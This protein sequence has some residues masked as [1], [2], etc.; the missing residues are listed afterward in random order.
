MKL[1]TNRALLFLFSLLCFF[2]VF[3][4]DD[5]TS[6]AQSKT[7]KFTPIPEQEKELSVFIAEMVRMLKAGENEKFLQCCINPKEI[8][9]LLTEMPFDKFVEGFSTEAAAGL[10]KALES[11]KGKEP[12]YNKERTTARFEVPDTDEESGKKSYINFQKVER[13][14]VLNNSKE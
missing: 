4:I 8:E 1:G 12:E 11:L 3:A 9:P 7:Y 5:N 10:L 13:R 6:K 14:W 2:A